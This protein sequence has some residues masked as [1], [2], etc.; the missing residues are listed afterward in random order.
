VLLSAYAPTTAEAPG[1]ETSA[2][3]A[4]LSV[5]GLYAFEFTPAA[6]TYAFAGPSLA[7][8][9]TSVDFANENPAFGI[10]DES[11]LSTDLGLLVGAGAA[12]GMFYTEVGYSIGGFS[13]LTV[14]AGVRF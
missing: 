10:E 2:L 9:L 13:Q 5:T 14:A 8:V 1:V 7:L 6:Q 4:D 11:D 3:Y 12:V